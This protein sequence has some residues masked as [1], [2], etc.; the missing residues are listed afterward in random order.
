MTRRKGRQRGENMENLLYGIGFALAALLLIWL[1]IRSRRSAQKGY[2]S[3]VQRYTDS[4]MMTVVDLQQDTL[5][6]WEEQEDGT[7]VQR[8]DTVYLPTYEYVV[9][10][11]TYR[12]SSR[13]S[14]GPGDLGRQVPGY[15]D[16]QNPE[17]IT[18]N[19]P[20]KPVL[21]GFF[22]FVFAAFLLFF[23]VM[24]LTGEA[25]IS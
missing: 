6:T 20:R 15:Y 1:G 17:D 9:D 13:Q 14:V 2:E 11:K 16:P 24:I 25:S 10:G 5:E 4:T 21:G 3:D 23:A 8:Y 7:R 18:E 12:R 19:R 22:F